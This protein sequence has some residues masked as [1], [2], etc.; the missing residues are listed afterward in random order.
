MVK[1]NIKKEFS[2]DKETL[3]KVV[4]DNYDFSWR[5]D[6]SKIEVTDDSH[7]VEYAKNNYPTYFT[8]T[9]KE[10]IQIYQFQ[11]QNS[12]MKGIWTGLFQELENGNILLDFT[13]ELEVKNSIMR[14]FAKAYLRK[15]QNQ[16]MKDLEEKLNDAKREK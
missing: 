3:W 4:T 6:L 15:Q 16:Y 7:F 5:S 9:K 2:C 8:I 11:I 14:L 10:P 1:A 12:N 13:E